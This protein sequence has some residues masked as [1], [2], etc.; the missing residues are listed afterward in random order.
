MP[1]PAITAI[2]R[3]VRSPRATRRRCRCERS[4]AR[5]DPGYQDCGRV[6]ARR[7]G[8]PRLRHKRHRPLRIG[9]PPSS[10]AW[11]AAS[12][13][14]ATMTSDAGSSPTCWCEPVGPL[15]APSS[16]PS[17]ATSATSVLEFPPSTPRTAAFMRGP[18]GSP[19]L[20]QRVDPHERHALLREPLED[21]GQCLAR[22][23]R[24]GVEQE[25]RA[26]ADVSRRPRQ[27]SW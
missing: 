13:A 12:A 2:P 25:D 18:V 5:S 15:T 11:R 20:R 9:S 22:G 16:R 10:P 4:G 14:R 27:A 24:P 1:E 3:R 6:A 8:C 19:L 23:R 21:R 17:A 26:V 7:L